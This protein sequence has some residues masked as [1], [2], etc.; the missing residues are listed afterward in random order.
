GRPARR[1][2]IAVAVHHAAPLNAVGVAHR[3]FGVDVAPEVG[4]L[5]PTGGDDQSH[6]APLLRLARLDAAEGA[7][8]A[9][10]GDLA[11][12]ADAERIERLVV[13]DQAVIDVDDVGGDVAI[14]RV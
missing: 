13:F 5:L 1:R 7:A 2:G 8:V 9:R 4:A 10:D 12:H 3:P 14:A 6:G 11:A